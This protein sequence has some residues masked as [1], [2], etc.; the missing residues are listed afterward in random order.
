MIR[1]RNIVGTRPHLHDE[2]LVQ[3]IIRMIS[4]PEG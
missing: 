4:K 3:E 1:I 2:L